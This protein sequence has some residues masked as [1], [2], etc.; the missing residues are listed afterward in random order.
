MRRVAVPIGLCFGI[1]L[2]V[3]AAWIGRLFGGLEIRRAEQKLRK[4]S[5]LNVSH[6]RSCLA[7]VPRSRA[8]QFALAAFSGFSEQQASPAPLL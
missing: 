2:A 4:A 8:Y 3:E 1:D 6:V 5:R 7:V